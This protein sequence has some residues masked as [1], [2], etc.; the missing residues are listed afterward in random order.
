[1]EI[2]TKNLCIGLTGSIGSGKTTACNIFQTL[3]AK[4]I[5]TDK[6]AHNLMKPK[7]TIWHKLHAKFG[8]KIIQT[9]QTVNRTY[10]RLQCIKN[11]EVKSWLESITH[12]LIYAEVRQM[13]TLETNYY[14]IIE[15]PL[16][17]ETKVNLPLHRTV[18]V[19][20]SKSLQIQ[21]L[22]DRNNWSESEACDMIDLQMNKNDKAYLSDDNIDNDYDI[23]NL[24]V[25]V[26]QLH[27]FYKTL[28]PKT[29]MIN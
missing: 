12:P 28:C 10:L 16:L 19:N 1:M 14:F 26:K 15:I 8:D 18:C 23:N 22:K 24:T 13:L 25:Q 3:G 4:I 5:N 11:Q 27:N 2:S 6:I 7:S 20:T 29:I 9:D 21:R 17:F